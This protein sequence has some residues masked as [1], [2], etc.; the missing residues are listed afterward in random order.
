MTS[1]KAPAPALVSVII[2]TY[3]RSALLQEAVAS[4]LAQTYSSLEIVVVDDGSHDD[5]AQVI[6]NFS[7]ARIAYYYQEN[8]G[9][10]AARNLGLQFARGE[11]I[12]FLDDDDLYLPEKLA[13]QV[14]YLNHHP[15]VDCVASGACFIKPDGSVRLFWRPWRRVQEL[16]CQN[17]LLYWTFLPCTVLL[18]RDVFDRVAKW[19][20]SDLDRVE[21]TDFFNRLALA[22]CRFAWLEEILSEYRDHRQHNAQLFL[23]S[24]RCH[25][26][27]LDKLFARADLPHEI[28]R[29]RTELYRHY[30]LYAACR[31][32]SNCWITA[33]Q[34]SLIR[35]W[36]EHNG[37]ADAY[38]NA[39]LRMLTRMAA[40]PT[41]IEHPM[42]YI[43]FVFDHLPP[44]LQFLEGL[45]SQAMALIDG[46][47][48]SGVFTM[49]L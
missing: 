47:Q 40:E 9:R 35:S 13:H 46:C 20:D 11:F 30:Y 37:P 41:I 33:A 28:Q 18:R 3:N 4:V 23:A 10:S 38:T 25:R 29:L 7:D 43:H 49:E 1:L 8:A 45:R 2:P 31:D 34:R 14:A 32:Y 15:M 12:G 48:P 21:D 5:T 16:T 17:I 19:F 36:L 24:D 27:M 26:K 39:F 44:S 22:G 6:A 42:E